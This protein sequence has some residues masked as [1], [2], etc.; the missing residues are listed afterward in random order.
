VNVHKSTSTSTEDASGP[1]QSAETPADNDKEREAHADLQRAK[2]LV[3]LHYRV[4]LKYQEEGLD[5]ELE[6]A[7]SSVDSVYSQLSS[8]NA[9]R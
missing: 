2:D 7:R 4:K 6:K 1:L 9:A 5:L 3:E 8:K